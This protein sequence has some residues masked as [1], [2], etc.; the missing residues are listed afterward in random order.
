MRQKSRA[1]ATPPDR[2]N[3]GH[4][5]GHI[6]ATKIENSMFMRALA[7]DVNDSVP[8]KLGLK[9]SKEVQKHNKKPRKPSVYGAFLLF[10]VQ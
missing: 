6:R 8:P 2:I 1:V 9:A 7:I 4:K 3:W 10:N 5:R